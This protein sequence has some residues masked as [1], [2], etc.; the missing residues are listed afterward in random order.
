MAGLI[1]ASLLAFSV[2]AEPALVD[3]V[4]RERALPHPAI[5]LFWAAWCAPCRAEVDDIDTLQNAAAPLPV[6]VVSIDSVAASRRLLAHLPV[7]QTRFPSGSDDVLGAMM[8]DGG[9]ILPAAIALD[10]D[11]RICRRRQGTVD[12]EILRAWRRACLAPSG[13]PR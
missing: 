13:S 1:A 7:A 9:G 3:G 4:G 12:A 5:V 11:G 10:A 8:P 6:I 2:S